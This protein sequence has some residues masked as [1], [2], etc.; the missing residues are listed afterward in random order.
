MPNGMCDRQRSVKVF[1]LNID[2]QQSSFHF[3]LPKVESRLVCRIVAVNQVFAS[4]MPR[5][6]NWQGPEPERFGEH[7]STS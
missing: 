6:I 7:E 4:V 3:D 1:P 5:L 2:Y